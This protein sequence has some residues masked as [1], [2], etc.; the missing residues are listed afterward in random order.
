[1]YLVP[2]INLFHTLKL[3]PQSKES[4][5]FFNKSWVIDGTMII[6]ECLGTSDGAARSPR[7][8]SALHVA[9]PFLRSPIVVL[10]P[11][12]DVREYPPSWAGPAAVG[13]CRK[14]N[15]F[16]RSLER[17]L[18]RNS[19]CTWYAL[20]NPLA[21]IVFCLPLSQVALHKITFTNSRFSQSWLCE[22]SHVCCLNNSNKLIK[23]Q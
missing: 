21:S 8:V 18:R 19:N 17:W 23:N 12:D 13:K 14:P 1:M 6:E 3:G 2:K 9:L 10:W 15:Q 20:C 4:A 11:F 5:N 7:L 16:L 22:L